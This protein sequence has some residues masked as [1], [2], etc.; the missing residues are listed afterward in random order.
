MGRTYDFKCCHCH[1]HAKVSG[2]EDQGNH[3]EIQT[4]VCRGCRELRDV[5]TRLRRPAGLR[6]KLLSPGFFNPEI[7]PVL[8]PEAIAGRRI[9]WQSFPLRC[10]VNPVHAV[11]NWKDPGRCP[12]CGNYMEKN[13]YPARIWE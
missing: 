4:V 13:G 2:G 1:Y 10:P 8:L 6:S 9:I 11:E 3:C 12:R 7:P 5:L